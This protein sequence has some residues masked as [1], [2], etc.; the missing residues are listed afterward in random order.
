ME[1]NEKIVQDYRNYLLLELGF[2]ENSLKAYTYDV[3]LFLES[4]N[5]NFLESDLSDIVSHMTNLRVKGYS[6]DSI[7]R[8]LSGISS[9]FDFLIQEKKISNNPVNAV[10][11]PKK[12]DRIPKFLEF[13]D[14]DA[15]L[16]SPDQSSPFG[17]RDKVMLST[18]YST[19]V[20]VSELIN[21]QL[22]CVD[23]K[24]GVIKVSGKGGKERFVPIYKSLIDLTDTYLRIR[25][26]FFVKT[27]DNG[28]MFLNKYGEKLS[29]VACWQMIK[30]YCKTTG[31]KAEV[32][33]HTLRHSFATH[34]LT[35]GADLRTIQVFLGH[36]DISTTEIYT[37]VTDDKKRQVLINNHPRFS[38]RI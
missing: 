25:R 30:K 10:Q 7:L 9:F 27:K 4:I 24:R 12:W 8:S 15:L 6:V 34:L 14:V 16:D 20:R 35:N 11:K 29:R 2:A 3:Q 19:G 31:I 23:L 26:D 5:R 28:Y 38:K 1:S 22:S 33:P 13:K 18:L 36:S 21:I 37:H 17:I 32:S